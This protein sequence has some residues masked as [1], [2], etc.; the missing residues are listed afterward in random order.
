MEYITSV[1]DFNKV[2]TD[3]PQ[4]VLLGRSNV[5]KSSFINAYSNRKNLARVSKVPGKT[6]GLNYYLDK[7]NSLYIVDA[8]GYGYAKRDNKT[9]DIIFNLVTTY[10]K[11]KYANLVLLFVDFKVGPTTDDLMVLNYLIQNNF[12]FLV[13]LTKSDKVKPSEKVKTL[14]NIT[15]KLGKTSFFEISSEKNKGI[16]ELKNFIVEK[17]GG[18]NGK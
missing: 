6:I 10:L 16:I 3:L 2:P 18:K 4:V 11:N 13:V 17:L 12:E 9:R 15:D 1:F 5:G 14:K 7:N 8:P